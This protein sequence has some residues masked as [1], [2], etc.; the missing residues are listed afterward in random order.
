MSFGTYSGQDKVPVNEATGKDTSLPWLLG[1]FTLVRKQR[2]EQFN[3]YNNVN[4]TRDVRT[5]RTLKKPPE[6]LPS[7]ALAEVKHK[8]AQSWS[9]CKVKKG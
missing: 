1:T 6:L 7:S 9:L 5:G 4:V 2:N 8:I 3:H